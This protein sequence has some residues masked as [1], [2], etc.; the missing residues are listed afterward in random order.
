MQRIF[1]S[2]IIVLCVTMSWAQRVTENKYLMKDSV[3]FIIEGVTDNKVDSIVFW[4][5][6]PFI[7]NFVKHP[8]NDGHFTIKG[9]LP[10]GAFVQIGDGLGNDVHII[11]DAEPISVNMPEGEIKGSAVNNR[12]NEYQHR[13]WMLVKRNMELKASVPK[14]DWDNVVCAAFGE[15]NAEDF[16]QYAEQILLIPKLIEEGHHLEE[17]AIEDNKDNII[18]VY[19]LAQEASRYSFGRLEAMLNPEF[20]YVLHPAMANAR[21]YFEGLSKR[22]PGREYI[23]FAST[24]TLGTT[25]R[26]SDYIGKDNYILL[27]FWA[28]WCG[29]CLLEIPEIKDLHARYAPK[30]LKVIGISLD[31][32]R[33][34]WIK[35]IKK[36][37]LPWLNLSDLKY[38]DSEAAMLYGIVSIPQTILIAPNGKIV[39]SYMDDIKTALEEL[40]EEKE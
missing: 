39:A 9:R 31:R 24:D 7:D 19:F 33:D 2:L 12:F 1:S 40:L 3:D 16:P 8:V 10:Q 27:D 14:D 6:H 5:T 17:S 20:T 13:Q 4:Q 35:A 25:H 34:A 23:D 15:L 37:E 32:N 30:G 36:N 29:P 11:I 18:P 22:Q 28:S 21:D 26:L 38:W